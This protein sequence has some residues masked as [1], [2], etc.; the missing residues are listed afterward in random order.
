VH[1]LDTPVLAPQWLAEVRRRPGKKHTLWPIGA[2]VERVVQV[3]DERRMAVEDPRVFHAAFPD[4]NIPGEAFGVLHGR[5]PGTTLTGRL[6]CCA[7]RPMVLPDDYRQFLT[8]PGGPAGSD[9]AV[10]PVSPDAPAT[11]VEG[12]VEGDLRV[13]VGDGVLTAWRLRPTWQPNGEALD[14]LAADVAAVV[15]R[16]GLD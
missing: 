3:A 12:E 1:S 13:A 9:V 7:E 8:D 2:L 15:H 16:R 11:G 10:V 5:L 6:L 14:R 4:L